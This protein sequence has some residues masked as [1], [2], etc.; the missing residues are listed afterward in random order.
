[1]FFS[2]FQKI[3]F[4]Q[5]KST[6]FIGKNLTIFKCNVLGVR[7]VTEIYAGQSSLYFNRMHLVKMKQSWASTA[8][9][10]GGLSPSFLHTRQYAYRTKSGFPR[11]TRLCLQ[12]RRPCKPLYST[13]S[14]MSICFSIKSYTEQLCH[15]GANQFSPMKPLRVYCNLLFAKYMLISKH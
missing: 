2:Y 10:K 15:H 7:K 13:V 3:S 1:M 4:S 14:G 11:A 8:K 9:I 5:L 6:F 12:G